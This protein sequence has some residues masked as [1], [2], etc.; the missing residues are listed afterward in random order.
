M[1]DETARQIL[2]ELKAI[3]LGIMVL[4]GAV[5]GLALRHYGWKEMLFG[6]WQ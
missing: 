1:N 4:V 5:F 2:A 6:A 3:K